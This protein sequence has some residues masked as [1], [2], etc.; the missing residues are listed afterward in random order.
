MQAPS[1][2]TSGCYSYAVSWQCGY[3]REPGYG[4]PLSMREP[5]GFILVPRRL[6][7]T[8]LPFKEDQHYP[9]NFPG[10]FLSLSVPQECHRLSLSR[11]S[12]VTGHESHCSCQIPVLKGPNYVGN[13]PPRFSKVIM[14]WA[15]E[16]EGRGRRSGSSAHRI[17]HPR[18][19]QNR[20]VALRPLGNGGA[21]ALACPNQSRV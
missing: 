15:R 6:Y 2:S 18:V 7:S 3:S 4:L 20:Q 21:W 13:P 10:S 9:N 17:G 16:F 1:N 14:G 19:V 12:R 11:S 5:L 8:L